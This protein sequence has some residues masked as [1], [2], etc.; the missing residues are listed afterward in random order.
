LL[1]S[2]QRLEGLADCPTD[3]LLK[4]AHSVLPKDDS[5][6]QWSCPSAGVTDSV[7]STLEE[8]YHGLVTRYEHRR[9]KAIR[10]N[11]D[12]WKDFERRLRSH[13]VLHLIRKTSVRSPMRKYEFDYA[14]RNHQPHIIAPVSLDAE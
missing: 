12:V 3:D 9:N 1:T 5:S 8:I 14:W 6:L 11:T 13:H 7:D 4:I 10:S 2:F